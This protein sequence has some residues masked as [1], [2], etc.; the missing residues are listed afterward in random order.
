MA[1]RKSALKDLEE[2]PVLWKDRKRPMFGLP[3]SFTR[4]RLHDDRLILS[5]GFFSI[6]EDEVMLY[7]VLDFRVSM[8]LPQRIFRV[9]NVTVISADATNRELLLKDVKKPR[10]VKQLISDKTMEQRAK[11]RVKGYDMVGASADDNPDVFDQ[12]SDTVQIKFRIRNQT[13]SNF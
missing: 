6:T 8:T 5:K 12:L 2:M 4:Y 13:H 10:A 3:L 7:R 9:G 1:K 11:Y